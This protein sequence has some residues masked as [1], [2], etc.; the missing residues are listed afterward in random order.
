MNTSEIQ[1]FLYLPSAD[2]RDINLQNNMKKSL[3][4][5][6]NTVITFLLLRMNTPA[7]KKL[8][9]LILSS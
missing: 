6:R 8:F 4:I 2:K 9:F 7:I 5:I 3:S 1:E